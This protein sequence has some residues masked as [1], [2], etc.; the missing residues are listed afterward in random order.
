MTS[1]LMSAPKLD[2]T[3]QQII[4]DLSFP[5]G[6]SVNDGIPKESYLGTKF[7]LVLVN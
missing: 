2:S 5:R 6:L 1:P 4:L 7:K 3:E